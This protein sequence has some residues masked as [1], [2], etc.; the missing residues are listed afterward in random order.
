MGRASS[1]GTAI[2]LGTGPFGDSVTT[3]CPTRLGTDMKL[4]RIREAKPMD[5]RRVQLTLT[6][7]RVIERDLRPTFA[8]PAFYDIPSDETR[9]RGVRP[10]RRPRGDP[11]G[12]DHWRPG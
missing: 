11:D 4:V 5:D 3:H 1:P 2:G 8:G 6:D 9:V 7:G 12:R 10:A